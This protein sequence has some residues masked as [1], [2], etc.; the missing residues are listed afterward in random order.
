[1]CNI[2]NI[3]NISEQEIAAEGRKV[4]EFIGKQ[5]IDLVYEEAT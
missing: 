4:K 2:V 1:V 5:R 3:V